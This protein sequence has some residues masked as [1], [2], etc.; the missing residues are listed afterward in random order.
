M[1]IFS[2]IGSKANKGLTRSYGILLAISMAVFAQMAFAAGPGPFTYSADG[3]VVTDAATG[4][5]WRRC[6]EGQAWN[7]QTCKGAPIGFTF[8]AA[9]AHATTQTGWRVPNVKELSSIVD[10]TTLNPSVNIITFPSTSTGYYWTTTRHV[11]DNTYG[12]HVNFSAG[13]VDVSS[14]LSPWQIRLVR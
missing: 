8:R 1:N 14:L 3:S 10:T 2:F 13:T 5:V 12:W 6:S 4:L 9:L 7:G 11:T